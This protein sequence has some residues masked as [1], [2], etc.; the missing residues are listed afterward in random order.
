M[1]SC[2]VRLL[3]SFL[4]AGFCG[5]GVSRMSSESEEREIEVSQSN[6]IACSFVA[7]PFFVGLHFPVGFTFY[8]SSLCRCLSR[9]AFF[10]FFYDRLESI[11]G[12]RACLFR[13]WEI[14]CSMFFDRGLLVL[15]LV[16]SA[17]W[18]L[19]LLVDVLCLACSRSI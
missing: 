15:A 11:W 9:Q 19:A 3:S 7:L 14:I 1:K 8:A 16:L 13:V 17:V 12:S 10:A 4:A 2:G 6:G 5:D 18:F